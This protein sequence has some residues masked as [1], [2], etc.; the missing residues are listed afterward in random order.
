MDLT[1]PPALAKQTQ[2]RRFRP[3]A[4]PF[5]L[6]AAMVVALLLPGGSAMANSRYA[7]IVVDAVSGEVLHQEN[8]DRQLYPASLTKMMT[9][10]MAFKA[11]EDGT[12]TLDHRISISRT[13]AGQTPS[14]LGL[15]PGSTIRVEDAIYALVTKSANDI[16]T[17]VAEAISGTEFQFARHM[18][19]EARR[20]GMASTTFRNAS[21]LPHRRQVSTAHD[22]ALL[23]QAVIKDFPQYYHY[24]SADRWT[25]NG[26][27]YRNHNE[28]MRSYDG[29]DGLKTGY[30]RA[31]GFNLAA[32]AVRGRLRLVTVVFG[33]RTAQRRNREVARLLDE[34][35]ASRRG[36]LLIAR[37]SAP[38]IPPLPPRRPGETVVLA[39]AALDSAIPLPPRLPET[40]ERSA[41][42][43]Q[44][45]GVIPEAPAR[46][47]AAADNRTQIAEAGLG[48]DQ[49]SRPGLPSK[50]WGIQVGAFFDATMSQR[51]IDAAK[52]RAPDL[53]V[54]AQR[55]VM[56]VETS[57]GRMFRARIMGLD[58][59]DAYAAC[60]QLEAAG[61]DCLPLS[62]NANF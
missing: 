2:P 41:I 21:G 49:G 40:A 13:A 1:A 34:A 29:M 6:I 58:E 22:M 30:I 43:V 31:A 5:V 20:L 38:F 61:S 33:G 19:A 57:R 52:S 54:S 59:D 48:V 55:I 28:L 14:R 12:F 26:R 44:H 3:P 53:L 42:A 47:P 18:T 9:L 10:Y 27:T 11:L 50:V 45:T 16:A 39:T 56:P 15:A 37:G 60:D 24:F 17:A 7:A 32:S 23:S 35:F 51:A 4:I 36:Q 46:T 62:P 25:F 8:A